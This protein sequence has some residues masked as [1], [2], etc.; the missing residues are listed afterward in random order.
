M[1]YFVRLHGCTLFNDKQMCYFVKL[2]GCTLF[3]Y[4]LEVQYQVELDGHINKVKSEYEK[5]KTDLESYL[6]GPSSAFQR[7]QEENS[8]LN[9]QVMYMKDEMESHQQ[10]MNEELETAL[11]N[12]ETAL[13][14]LEKE[15]VELSMQ[16]NTQREESEQRLKEDKSNQEAIFEKELR[17]MKKDHHKELEEVKCHHLKGFQLRGS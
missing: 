9:D 5:D 12:T 7:L 10:E 16:L 17:K 14:Q 8:E 6:T 3:C 1:C 2:H 4:S 13:R 11:S 15:K